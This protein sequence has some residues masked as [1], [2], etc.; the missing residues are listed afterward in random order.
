MNS[1]FRDKAICEG[2]DGRRRYLVADGALSAWQ[3]RKATN[4]KKDRRKRTHVSGVRSV[5]CR[6]S[7]IRPKDAVLADLTDCWVCIV[8]PPD[9]SYTNN[10]QVTGNR[11]AR[12]TGDREGIGSRSPAACFP[13]LQKPI[14]VKVYPKLGFL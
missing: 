4:R 11:S 12:P 14:A 1:Y 7:T 2:T 9:H 10:P 5:S 13:P 8:M 3:S 6:L